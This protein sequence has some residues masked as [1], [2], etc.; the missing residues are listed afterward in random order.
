VVPDVQ[1]GGGVGRCQTSS[2][3]AGC[4]SGARRP[5][6]RRGKTERCQMSCLGAGWC[7]GGVRH[8]AWRWDGVAAVVSGV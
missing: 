4:S 1:L 6:W 5:A 8:P 7:G 2:L 3:E